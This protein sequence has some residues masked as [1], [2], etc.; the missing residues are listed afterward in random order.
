MMWGAVPTLCQRLTRRRAEQ[1]PGPGVK[2]EQSASL[3]SARDV[4]TDPLQ[5]QS[6]MHATRA[7][8]PAALRVIAVGSLGLVLV[9]CASNPKHGSPAAPRQPHAVHQRTASPAVWGAERGLELISWIVADAP[10]PR[11]VVRSSRKV[12][13]DAE[14][15]SGE[16][17]A[18]NYT[19][20]DRRLSIEQALASYVDRPVPIPDELRFRWHAAGLRIVAVP[21]ADLPK[22]QSSLRL[23]GPTQRQW[24]G[25]VPQWTDVIRGPAFDTARMVATD[26]GSM[27]IEAGRLRLLARSWVVPD[28]EGFGRPSGVLPAALRLELVPQHEPQLSEPHRLLAGASNTAT[29]AEGRLFPGLALGMY[30]RAGDALVIIPDS[31]ESDWTKPPSESAG[32]RGEAGG[33]LRAEATSTVSIGEAMLATS[34]KGAAPRMRGV[35]VLIP[36]V[37]QRYELR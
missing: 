3:R 19:I 2:Q 25:E 9:A 7:C 16:P 5:R 10:R 21:V 35:I 17:P 26:N 6:P 4:P 15:E 22:L 28:P 33:R 34:S 23:V 18:P 8:L 32:K 11:P 24:L 20:V 14:N 37:P 31:P 30:L 1:I 13:S 27:L 12:D 29:E 36:Y